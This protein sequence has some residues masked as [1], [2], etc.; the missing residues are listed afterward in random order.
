M[1][2]LTVNKKA[3]IAVHVTNVLTSIYSAC[4][5]WRTHTALSLLFAVANGVAAIYMTNVYFIRKPDQTTNQ[6]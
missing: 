2:S 5:F 1:G 4:I 6:L 3:Y